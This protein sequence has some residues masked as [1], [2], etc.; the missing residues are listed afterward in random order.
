MSLFNDILGQI[1][2][3]ISKKNSI[4]ETIADILSNQLHTTITPDQITIR[5]TTLN[6]KAAPTIKMAI[7]L[8]RQKLLKALQEKEISITII[9]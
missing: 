9:Q 6:I 2:Q 1:E 8:N 5:D 7:T 3:R 4:K